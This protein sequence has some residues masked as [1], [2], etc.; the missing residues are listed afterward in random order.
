MNKIIISLLTVFALAGCKENENMKVL[1]ETTEGNIVLQLYDDTPQ[2]RD[3][4]VKLVK[5]G[6]YDGVIFH[7]VIPQFMIQTGDP[8]SKNPQPGASYGRGGPD[9]RIPAEILPNRY[10][11][12]G[13]LAAA[14]TNN[15][16]KESSGSQFYIVQGNV[17]SSD[18]LQS[19]Q[20]GKQRANPDFRFS[21]E[22]LKAY[23][24]IGGV[25]HLDGDY[26]VFGEVTE[27]LD[28]VDKIAA[29]PTAPGDRP[30]KDI[31]ITK[32]SIK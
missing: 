14:R 23:T 6:Y 1:L 24:E 32:A 11:R 15:P 30:V 4:F 19:M 9:Y 21:D 3:N 29:A 13:A 17:Y 27:G 31:V 28:I 12:K 7:R 22:A 2:H 16:K 25:P 20:A 26:T 5:E 10:H 8:E 18:D